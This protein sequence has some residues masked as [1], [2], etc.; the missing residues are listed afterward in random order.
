MKNK[1][2]PRNAIRFMR[3]HHEEQN[4]AFGDSA[5]EEQNSVSHCDTILLMRNRT[6]RYHPP[7]PL[8]PLLPLRFPPSLAP[9]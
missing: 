3:Q 1:I 6:H 9:P 4:S 5:H 8:R 7:L 2:P